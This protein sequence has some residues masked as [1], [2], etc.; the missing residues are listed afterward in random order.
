MSTVCVSCA[1]K[2][3][4]EHLK[5]E[6]LQASAS[7]YFGN[8]CQR[9]LSKLQDKNEDLLAVLLLQET[10]RLCFGENCLRLK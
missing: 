6:R 2:L 7:Q 5:N 4:P 1:L 9:N 3:P 10:I 8:V